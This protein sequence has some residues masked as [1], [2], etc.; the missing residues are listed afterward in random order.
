[1]QHYELVMSA[2]PPM[3]STATGKSFWAPG[4]IS[5]CVCRRGQ[6][7]EAAA[8]VAELL[9]VRPALHRGAAARTDR[10]FRQSNVPQE[11]ERIVAGARK[12]GLPERDASWLRRG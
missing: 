8:A 1:M 12:A 4:L 9:K 10:R 11:F 7:A 2:E 6:K 3:K 5:P